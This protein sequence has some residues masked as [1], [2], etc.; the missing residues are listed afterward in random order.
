MAILKL[1][2][3]VR[4]F[5]PA[6]LGVRDLL[7][8]DGRIA[9]IGEALPIPTGFGEVEVCDAGGKTLIPGLIDMHIHMLGGGGEGGPATRTPEI[10][11]SE[12]T[13]YGVTTAV[14]VLGT[15]GT[16][17]TMPA[18]LTKAKAL[19][20]E[21]ITTFVYTG[22]YEVPTPTITGK[23]RDDVILIEK[24]I[25]VGEIA[26]SDHR[27][28]HPTLD[29][30]ARLGMEARVG[31]MIGGK[32]GLLHLH[33]GPGKAGLTPI[34]D[35][36]AKSDLPIQNIL[37]THCSRSKE[38][39]DQAV[40][41][42]KEG[43]QFDLTAGGRVCEHLSYV[44]KAGAPLDKVTISSDGN[45]S[46]PRF[47]AKGNFLGLGVGSVRTVFE[48]FVNMIT[49]MQMPIS[50]ALHIVSCNQARLL[51]LADRKGRIAPGA[52]ADLVLLTEDYS[53]DKVW[54]KGRLM[55]DAGEPVVWGTFEGPR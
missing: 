14:G 42:A 33:I 30:L 51:N 47:D 23:V 35:L 40:R 37:P 4:I 25:G 6:E 8:A 41:L 53:I 7:I 36:L 55:V 31:G 43:G 17:R 29:E 22:S 38:T 19:E 18:L 54:A 5:A 13:R 10:T 9:C 50:E 52:D 16:T 44:L 11:L 3:N 27:S 32:P 28:A 26:I 45:G 34:F 20:L 24:V 12:I 1:L 46:L 21:G 49:Q 39:L 2:Q 15:D 48:A